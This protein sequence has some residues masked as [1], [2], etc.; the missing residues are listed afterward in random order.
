MSDSPGQHQP[1]D[2]GRQPATPTEQE[3]ELESS[4]ASILMADEMG[5]NAMAHG[6]TVDL[7][8]L[9][10]ESLAAA[11]AIDEADRQRRGERESERS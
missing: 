3:Q 2:Q 5:A 7:D 9:H 8:R 10:E 11:A 6:A 1:E 4:N